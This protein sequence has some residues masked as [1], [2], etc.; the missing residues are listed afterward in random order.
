MQ[1][2][3]LLGTVFVIPIETLHGDAKPGDTYL[4]ERIGY[5]CVDPGSK[6]GKPVFNRTVAL[7]DTWANV[8]KQKGGQK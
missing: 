7:K 8:E 6:P 3:I 4:F 5:F 2:G 1:E